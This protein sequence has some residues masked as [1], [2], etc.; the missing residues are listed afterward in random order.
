M[1]RALNLSYRGS[2]RRHSHNELCKIAEARTHAPPIDRQ[3]SWQLPK[4]GT[5][6]SGERALLNSQAKSRVSR[7]IILRF[8]YALLKR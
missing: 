5:R 1:A 3:V 8:R 2:L 6:P 4:L 7:T